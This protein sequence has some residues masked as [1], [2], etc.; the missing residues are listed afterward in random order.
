M[1]IAVLLAMGPTPTLF[2]VVDVR[3]TVGVFGM[4][5]AKD[6]IYIKSGIIYTVPRNKYLLIHAY[7][8]KS[9][10]SAIGTISFEGVGMAGFNVQPHSYEELDTG[11]V[12]QPL[13][14]VLFSS[15]SSNLYLVARLEDL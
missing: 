7:G 11:F 2:E 9:S 13:D 1:A 14:D 10:Q 5:R 3:G 4:H 12:A 15:S 6:A 8:N